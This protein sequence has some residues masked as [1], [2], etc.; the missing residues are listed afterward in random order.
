MSILV[1]CLN[2]TFQKTM[3]FSQVE[4]GEVNRSPK[5]FDIPSGKGVNV[6]RILVQLGEKAEVLTHLGGSRVEEF[7][8]LCQDEHIP[9]R[10]FSETSPIRTCTTVVEE[11]SHSSTELVEEPLAVSEKATGKALS[12]YQTLLPHFDCVIITGTKAPGYAKD[13]YPRMVKEA[14]AQGKL[15]VLDQKGED[16]KACLAY[17]PDIA[18][19]NL[20]ELMMSLSATGPV[21]EGDANLDR[22]EAVREVA[23]K[24]FLDHGTRLVVSRGKYPTWAYN[25]KDLVEIAGKKPLLPIVNT[26][27]CG[28]A[29]TAGMTSRLLQKESLEDAVAFGMECAV[30]NAQSL[31]HGL[32][33]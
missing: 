8:A 19:P 10:F 31:K 13:L 25:G 22:K 32:G 21:R 11:M 23:R 15:V 9:L 12:L 30:K 16:L 26:I 33:T 18:K 24:V 7:L 3:V 27:G 17:R 2:P 14:K 5:H 6:A 4:R 20:S 28:D 1:V 29:L